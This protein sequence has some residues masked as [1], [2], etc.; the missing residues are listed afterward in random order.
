MIDHF[1]ANNHRG[2]TA[3]TSIVFVSS[4]SAGLRRAFDPD[5]D[6]PLFKRLFFLHFKLH[7]TVVPL[8]FLLSLSGRKAMHG[9][10]QHF[11]FSCI[12]T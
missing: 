7:L 3:V 1:T 8:F 9:E 10:K 12:C 5:D 4:S 11:T 6:I 2:L